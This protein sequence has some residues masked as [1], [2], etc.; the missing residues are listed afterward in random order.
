VTT[1][2]QWWANAVGYEVYV[3]SFADSDA[4]GVGDIAGIVDKLDH[5][6]WLGVDIV[7]VTPFFRS[8]MADFGYDVADY[9]DVDPLF[10]SIEDF[11]ALLARAHA[12]GLKVIAD[13]VP[14]HSSNRHPWFVSAVAD[15]AGLH[16]DY[17]L[18]RD[19]AP[20]GG[21]PNNWLSHFGGPAWTLEPASG[22]YYCHL[23]LPEQPD[24]NWRNPAVQREFEE[25]LRF[26][27]TRGLDGFRI[28][29]AQG[30]YKDAR[31]RDNPVLRPLDEQDD[32]REK[33]A[34]LDH[35]HDLLQ[36]ETLGIY[37]AWN[38]IA[39]QHD[40]V[41]VGE[42]Y[43][44][45]PLT[46]AQLLPGDG[47]HLGFWFGTMQLEW[48]ADAVRQALEG[49]ASL[50]GERT[51]WVSSSHDDHRPVTRFGGGDLG[52]RRSLGLTTL[53]F[54]LPGVPFLYQGEELG[55]ADAVLRAEDLADPLAVRNAN[56]AG[57]DTCR[58][59][60]P[61]GPGP[62]LGF[63]EAGR[64][65]LPMSH[66]APESV[67]AQRADPA[68][69][70]HQMRA[71][72]ALRRDLALDPAA[73]PEWLPADEQVVGFRRGGVLFVLNADVKPVRVDVAPHAELLFG[74][75]RTRIAAGRL[76][77][78]PSVAAVVREVR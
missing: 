21:P 78:D 18:W 51:G 28:D 31:F 14:N 68:S 49:P 35:V 41:L 65:W 30:L 11:D 4:D 2:D 5:L 26:W 9:T 74:T 61:W 50:V 64:T 53:L 25:I 69:F 36:P 24:L 32:A 55:L 71:L 60:M 56:T 52:R 15:P 20:D 57:R 17:Y 44:D 43:V 72:V 63:S 47:L 23:F 66:A 39:Q 33:F 27:F 3:R 8:P 13:L 54:G 42:T 76:D 12:L 40:A 1:D 48:S 45:S 10:G 58:T 75:G 59:P 38:R 70:L 22:Q 16:R 77:I 37:R 67:D 46:L 73:P 62:N 19:P 34:S 6:A 7:W 29:V